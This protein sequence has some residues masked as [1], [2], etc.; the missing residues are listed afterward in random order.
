M[1]TLAD[2]AR[3]RVVGGLAP[4]DWSVSRRL[5]AHYKVICRV[6]DRVLWRGFRRR[7]PEWAL[8]TVIEPDGSRRR[9][10][11]IE[12][13]RVLRAW[14]ERGGAA[15]CPLPAEMAKT[16]ARRGERS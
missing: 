4:S 13:A 1:T 14:R 16:T 12:S 3:S 8:V 9:I 11:E 15:F 2:L 5:E 7:L 10:G 6:N